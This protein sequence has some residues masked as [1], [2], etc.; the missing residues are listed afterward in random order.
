MKKWEVIPMCFVFYL[1]ATSSGKSGIAMIVDKMS[2]QAH[3]LSLPPNSML[4]I[5]P[6][7]IFMRF[8]AIMGFLEC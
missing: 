8:I 1:P 7:Y 6:I 5:W 4:L 3:F 2:R